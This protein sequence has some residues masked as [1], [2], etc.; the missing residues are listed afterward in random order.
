MIRFYRGGVCCVLVYCCLK[1]LRKERRYFNCEILL[2]HYIVLYNPTFVLVSTKYRV[3]SFAW[4]IYYT[5]IHNNQVKLFVCV[6]NHNVPA[7]SFGEIMCHVLTVSYT[8]KNSIIAHIYSYCCLSVFSL[9]IMRLPQTSYLLCWVWTMLWKRHTGQ[10]FT[11]PL[12]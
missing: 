9:H 12:S 1:A 11:N 2:C 3:Y 6:W 5:C 4:A 10:W 8:I 7:R